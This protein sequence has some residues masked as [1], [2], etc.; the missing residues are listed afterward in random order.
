MVWYFLLFMML[1]FITL[2]TYSPSQLFLFM[3]RG[4]TEFVGALLY[5]LVL[6]IFYTVSHITKTMW[7]KL[8][9]FAS[10]ENL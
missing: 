4:L 1:N 9:T 10:L 7:Q 2:F 5:L 8:Y 6:F 3:F